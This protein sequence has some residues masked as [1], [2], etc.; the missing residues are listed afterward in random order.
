MSVVLIAVVYLVINL[1]IGGS[2][3]SGNYSSMMPIG[4]FFVLFILPGIIAQQKKKKE[5]KGIEQ[6][7]YTEDL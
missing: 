5:Q 3:G 7:H 2:N 4:T 1:T 6:Q